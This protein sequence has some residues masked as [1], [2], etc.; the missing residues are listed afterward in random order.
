[1]TSHLRLVVDNLTDPSGA[2]RRAVPDLDA[3][4]ASIRA[5]DERAFEFVY[6]TLAEPLIDFAAGLLGDTASARDVVAD[7]FVALWER[8]AQWAPGHGVRA[9]LFVA[10]RHRAM[11]VLRNLRRHARAHETMAA[12][13]ETPGMSVSPIPVD[14]SLDLADQIDTVLRTL[15]RLPAARRTAMIL[16]WQGELSVAEIARTMDISPN[17][18]KL[19]LSRGLNTLKQLLQGQTE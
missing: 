2:S 18:V 6:R 13:Q 17:A 9:Y 4:V 8:R 15:A 1:M 3:Y 14:R 19:H 11:D 7:V 5:G 16:R 10:V 12:D